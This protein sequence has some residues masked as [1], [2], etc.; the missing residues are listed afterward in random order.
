ML[1]MGG[2]PSVYMKDLVEKLAFVKTEVLSKFSVGE[3]K[4]W[5]V[6]S[7]SPGIM[8]DIN[9]VFGVRLM[10]LVRFV[11]RTFVLHVSIAKPLGENGKLQL[12]SDMAELE[13]ALSVFMAESLQSKRG[14]NLESVGENYRVLRAMRC[15]VVY[16]TCYFLIDRPQTTSFPGKCP[17]GFTKA[18]S[19]PPASDRTAPHPCALTD[20]AS[21]QPAWMARG[22]VCAMG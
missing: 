12:T 6:F 9:T 19:G 17:A 13:F 20:P 10:S 5:S 8:V 2:G 16:F 14:G 15:V 22:R 7:L 3:E 18:Y 11:I 4:E 1:S 21:T